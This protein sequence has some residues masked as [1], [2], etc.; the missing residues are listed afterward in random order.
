MMDNVRKAR[1]GK[2]SQGKEIKADK[3]M[4]KFA[5]GGAVDPVAAAAQ[6]A[7]AANQNFVAQAAPAPAIPAQT[8][9]PQGLAATAPAQATTPA[10]APASMTDQMAAYR[11]N[12]MNQYAPTNENF[13]RQAYM[14]ILGRAPDQAG[15]DYWNQQIQ[16]GAMT[17]QQ[18]AQN[19]SG[20]KE[21]TNVGNIKDAMSS[22]NTPT[23]TPGAINSLVN[24]AYQGNLG[25]APDQAGAAYWSQQL[26]SGKLT[27]QQ[28]IDQLKASSE[29]GNKAA[30]QQASNQVPSGMYTAPNGQ[31]WS[32]YDAYQ[33]ANRG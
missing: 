12:M 31:I 32:S 27:P 11:S 23:M 33:A 15:A 1:T 10:A 21:A 25:R 26:Q 29:F 20:S 13:V 8:T 24:S 3:F 14:N 16:S 2:K 6:A 22:L 18:V 5:D 28:F 7:Q 17:P 4:P 19:I 9:A 30:A